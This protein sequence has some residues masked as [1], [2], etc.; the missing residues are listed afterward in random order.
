MM[1]QERN[2]TG[3]AKLVHHVYQG[4]DGQV[5]AHAD[6]GDVYPLSFDETVWYCEQRA[7]IADFERD[8]RERTERLTAYIREWCQGIPQILQAIAVPNPRLMETLLILVTP[9]TRYP[10]DIDELVS[11]FEIELSTRF[12][13]LP[14]EV[15]IVPHDRL[16]G[17]LK[18]RERAFSVY[19][20]PDRP[21]ASS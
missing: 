11:D 2:T 13:A 10:L 1:T 14:F 21:Q 5:M 12:A 18:G 15:M 9:G 16:R 17:V 7:K 8:R 3:A 6:G 19:G 20:R 4:V